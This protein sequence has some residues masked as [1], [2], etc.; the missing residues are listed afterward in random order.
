MGWWL[1]PDRFADM[2]PSLTPYHYATNNPLK[3]ID[4][5]GDSI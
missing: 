3:F 1:T 4:V 2:Y 5:N